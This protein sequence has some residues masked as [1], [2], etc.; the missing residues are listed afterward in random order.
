[1]ALTE[2]Q[3]T[4]KLDEVQKIRFFLDPDPSSLGLVSINHKLAELQLSKDRVASLLLEAMRNA[5]EHEI[6]KETIQ[7]KHDRQ[8]EYLMTTEPACLN[9]KSAEARSVQGRIKM[10]DLVMELHH[11]DIA[12][13]KAGWYLKILQSVHSNL[14]SANSNLSR[15]I[16]VVQL[17]SNLG[18]G[19]FTNPQNRGITK[20]INL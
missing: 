15:Q 7:H 19:H 2:E 6:L 10:P 1:M 11:A 9:A 17:S 18:E 3:I 12:Q 14:E 13:I 20:N 4:E 16:T 5:A 8:L